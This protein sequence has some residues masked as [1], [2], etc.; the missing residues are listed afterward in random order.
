MGKFSHYLLCTDFDGS[1]AVNAQISRENA[2]AVRYFQQEGGLF[3]FSSGRGTPFL[4]DI[5]GI[6]A[7]APLV[8]MSGTMISDPETGKT[9]MEFPLDRDWRADIRDMILLSKPVRVDVNEGNYWSGEVPLEDY[10][11][12][13]P[14]VCHKL[15]IVKAAEDAVNTQHLLQ[16]AYPKRYL[17]ERSWPEGIEIHSSASGKGACLKW[18]KEWSKDP[19][20]VTVALG[21]YENDISMLL[22]ADIGYAPENAL[23]SV[24]QAADRVTVSCREHA[25]RRIIEEL[26]A[27]AP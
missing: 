7:N 19:D 18:L 5:P 24:K 23:D 6:A 8:G 2:E 14:D 27:H 25:V 4:R 17:F 21:D 15:V 20:L 3:T 12:R 16:K 1:I 10:L 26:E 11:S 13:L 22:D 9:L